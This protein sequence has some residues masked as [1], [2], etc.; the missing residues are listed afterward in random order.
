MSMTVNGGSA[1]VNGSNPIPTQNTNED[2]K[3]TKRTKEHFL[4]YKF[5]MSPPVGNPKK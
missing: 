4:P 5:A 2:L 3:V 1:P